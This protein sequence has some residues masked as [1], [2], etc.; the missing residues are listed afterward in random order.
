MKPRKVL[1]RRMTPDGVPLELA[2]EGAHHVLRLRGT[3][4][5]TSATSGSERA[6]ASA[7]AEHVDRP[8]RILV[9]GLGMGFTCR[10]A[11]DTFPD[12]QEIVVAEIFPHVIEYNRG[13]LSPLAGQPLEDSRVRVV[14]ADVRQLLEGGDWNVVLLD[15]DNGPEAFSRRENASL[16]DRRGV[17]RLA[18]ALAPGG[19]VVIWS[20][21]AAPVFERR[22]RSAGLDTCARRVHARGD[23]RRGP[24]HWLITAARRRPTR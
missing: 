12:A 22:L 6:M 5:M 20:A 10:A 14:A 11:L 7:A 3:V 21:N 16:Y 1:D 4:L 17:E 13:V 2:V 24:R 15:V 23:A 19:A 18:R 8:Q 9:G